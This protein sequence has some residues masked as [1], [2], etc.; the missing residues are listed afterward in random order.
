M[1][2]NKI[3]KALCNPIRLKLIKCIATKDKTVSEL[4]QNCGLAQSAVSQHLIKLKK[5]GLVKDTKNGR[6]VYYSLTDQNLTLISDLLISLIN[7]DTK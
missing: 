3:I 2:E 6:E 1:Q 4:I 7:K 5:A